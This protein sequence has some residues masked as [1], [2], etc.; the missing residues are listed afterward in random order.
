VRGGR[1]TRGKPEG[2]IRY[3]E[4]DSSFRPSYYVGGTP[5]FLGLFSNLYPPEMLHAVP[6]R[7]S[8]CPV[9]GYSI[10]FAPPG[11]QTKI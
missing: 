3:A 2:A 7:T 5:S 6:I 1:D 11:Y 9:N 4:L 10:A 8:S